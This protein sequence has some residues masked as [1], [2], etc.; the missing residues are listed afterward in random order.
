VEAVLGR[1]AGVSSQ[2]ALL[3]MLLGAVVAMPL[4]TSVRETDRRTAL[5][6]VASGAVA[7][8]LGAVVGVTTAQVHV[9]GL[10][11]FTVVTFVA[12]WLRRFG[13]RWFTLGFLGWQAFFFSLFLDPPV[14]ALPFMVVAIV[15]ATGWVGVLLV[16]VLRVDPEVALSRTVRALRARARAAISAAIDVLD[17]SRGPG[18]PDGPADLRAVQAMRG[19]LVQLSEVSLLLDGQLSQAG[20]LPAHLSAGFM[21]RW[22]IDIEVALDEVCGAVLDLAHLPQ[23]PEGVQHD[24][25]TVLGSVGWAPTA[26]ALG[27]ARALQSHGHAGIAPARRLG[28]AAVLLLETVD[29]W[30]HPALR[31][32]RRDEV[33]DEQDDEEPQFEQVV[34]L[35]SGNLPGSA[36]LAEQT[37]VRDGASRW[38]PSRWRLTTRQAVQ[39]AVA[40]GLSIVIGDLISPQRY[41]WAVIASFIAFTGTSTA[42]ETI[43]KSLSRIAGTVAGLVVAVAL[44][45][46]TADSPVLVLTSLGA[47][48]FLAFYLQALSY[49]A[50]TFF[51]T[52]M[53]GEL[54]ALLHTF[55]DSLLLLRL[56]E[57]AVGAVV[58]IGV[59]LVVLPSGTRA[60]LR[61]A[62]RAFLTALADL[63]QGCAAHLDGSD[64]DRDLIALVVRSGA[65]ARQVVRTHQALTRGRVFGTGREAL[66][67]RISVL[68]SADAVARTLAARVEASPA[69]SSL[70]LAQACRLV[71]AEARRLAALPT[72]ITAPP[73]ASGEGI[74]ER[75]GVVLDA[76]ESDP[77]TDRVRIVV[78]RL[79]DSLALLTPRPS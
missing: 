18:E 45:N 13:P 5:V 35:F 40:A 29:E 50:M 64:A 74:G 39:A 32:D 70:P 6:T 57:T 68:G 12:V 61:V 77:G 71:E 27:H 73:K 58:G 56:E 15:L 4:S 1:V 79:A 51:I 7:A 36:P 21:R 48:I 14:A 24:A 67:H 34:T 49:T 41:Y 65:A 25:R 33:L 31:P 2:T 44:A 42:G 78:R 69:G 63:L 47:C 53:L 54:Y 37:H 55:T 28:A 66:G 26:V 10:V 11:A 76:L 46:A 60:T 52:L 17:S 38:S 8:A 19:Q 23:L 30:D 3:G 9:L 16:T 62:R 72:L 75:V 43:R 22:V 59:C 20:S